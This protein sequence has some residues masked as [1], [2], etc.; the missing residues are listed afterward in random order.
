MTTSFDERAA[1][2]DDDPDRRRRATVVAARINELVQPTPDTRVL[3]Y[4][5]G[6]GLLSF[7]LKSYVGPITMADISEGMLEQIEKKI[8][9]SG[10]PDLRAIRLDLTSGP[11]PPERYDLVCLQMIL[12]HIL[13]T[14]GIL[15]ALHQILVPGGTLAVADLDAE[16]GTFHSEAFEGY[17][18]FDRADLREKVRHAGFQE[19][20]FETVLTIHK[21][22]DGVE[23]EY[24]MFLMLARS[25]EP[26]PA[27]DESDPAEAAALVYPTLGG[28]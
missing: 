3:E 25:F 11:V 26:M 21:E 27:E 2:W 8:G 20:R 17:L 22:R 14:D 1:T 18:G 12:H 4:G 13:D 7:A 24:P 23:R 6:T 16:D 5:A 10:L 28:A 15:R 9:L 19:V